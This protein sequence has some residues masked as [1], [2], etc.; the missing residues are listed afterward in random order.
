M[1]RAIGHKR[2]HPALTPASESWKS[3][4]LPPRDGRLSS[5]RCPD[6]ARTG[7]RIHDRYRT[8]VRRPNC[9]ATETQAH[10]HD[11]VSVAQ[12]GTRG[13]RA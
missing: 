11:I 6:N 7:N 9:C 2:T 10:K 3:I 13:A 4:F 1:L 8:E 12:L 5:P